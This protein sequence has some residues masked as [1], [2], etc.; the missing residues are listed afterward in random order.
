VSL[1]STSVA[2][3]KTSISQQNP[4]K[5][6]LQF[7]SRYLFDSGIFQLNTLMDIRQLFS[8]IFKKEAP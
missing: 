8:N 4:V 6:Q 7:M 2:T 1:A 5:A 3:N